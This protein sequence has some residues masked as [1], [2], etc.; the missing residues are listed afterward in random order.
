MQA[1]VSPNTVRFASLKKPSVFLAGS[2]DQG[3]TEDWQSRMTKLFEDHDVVFF[4]PR[5][6]DWDKNAGDND[7]REQIYWE[8]DALAAVDAII[9]Y[10]ASD[11]L[12]PISLLELGLHAKDKRVVVVCPPGYWRRTNVQVICARHDIHVYD[13]LED[14]M[15]ATLA[16][17]NFNFL[18]YDRMK[19]MIDG[20]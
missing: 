6:P 16:L 10:F 8:L 12:A 18:H 14:G 19:R 7:V 20:Q 9:V 4:N 15:K 3:A 11:S 1:V 5:R 13:N 17:A 2:I